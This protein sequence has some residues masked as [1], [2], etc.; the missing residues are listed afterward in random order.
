M[1]AE[2]QDQLKDIV[3]I[4]MTS[5]AFAAV[6]ADGSCIMWGT[7][8]TGGD[9]KP[10]IQELVGDGDVDGLKQDEAREPECLHVCY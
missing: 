7:A 5:S 1:G 4:A 9:C 2:V 10:K 8:P 3:D 6:R